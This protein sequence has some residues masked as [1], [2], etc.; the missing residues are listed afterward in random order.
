VQGVVAGQAD[1]A[2]QMV[3]KAP[4]VGALAAQRKGLA[5]PREKLRQ[6]S[7]EEGQAEESRG[8]GGHGLGLSFRMRGGAVS[9]DHRA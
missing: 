6:V 9:S 7:Q 1:V 5:E 4:K 2:Q 3:V 8:A